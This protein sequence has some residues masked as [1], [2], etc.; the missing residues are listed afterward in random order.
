MSETS[1]ALVAIAIFMFVAAFFSGAETGFTAS[2]RAKLT[3]I[4]RRGSKRARRALDLSEKPE[5]LIYT[6]LLGSNLMK[7]SATA[8]ATYVVVQEYGTNGILAAAIIMAVLM[9]SLCDVLPKTFALSFPER[10][11]MSS[12]YVLRPLV[13]VLAPFVAA[14]SLAAR[15]VFRLFGFDVRENATVLTAHDELRGAIDLHRKE[16]TLIKTDRD[17]L[18]GILDLKDLEVA[19]IMVHRTKMATLDANMPSKDMVKYMLESPH[20]RM[21]VW[22]DK[23]DNIIGMLACQDTVCSAA[24]GRRRC[25]QNLAG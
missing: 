9:L 19:D 3:E 18:G 4:E 2:S 1:L 17:M 20:T 21:P 6:L 7:V 23:H 13:I 16:D 24:K 5:N 22:K 11:A 12:V 10:A 15:M 8:I 25:Q 14:I